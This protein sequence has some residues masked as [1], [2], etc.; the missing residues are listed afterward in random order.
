MIDNRGKTS[1][2]AI[3]LTIVVIICLILA[4]VSMLLLSTGPSKKSDDDDQEPVEY[5][6]ISIFEE[7]DDF[8]KESEGDLQLWDEMD[9]ETEFM[10]AY[11]GYYGNTSQEYREDGDGDLAYNS[12]SEDEDAA[13]GGKSSE[14]EIEEADIVKI[15]GNTLYVLN[16]YRGL[17]IIDITDPDHPMII[18]RQQMF[19]QP[20]DMYV[21]DTKA[22]VILSSFYYYGF[23]FI[24]VG[25]DSIWS[26]Y[27]WEGSQICIVDVTDNTAPYIINKIELEGAVTDTRRVGD[28]IYAVSTEYDYYWLWDD[29]DVVEDGSSGDGDDYTGPN[30]YVISLNFADPNSIKEVDSAQ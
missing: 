7:A 11:Y 18:G 30:T 29:I 6:P 10:N 15:V 13:A 23:R 1:T 3:A 27:N 20:V 12:P 26:P 14:R 22:Y 9:G 21:V 28:V 24:E 17:I 4:S 19:G 8:V 2:K 25:G 16:T 5:Q